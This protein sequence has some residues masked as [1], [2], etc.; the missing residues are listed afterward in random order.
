MVKQC[1][2]PC[3]TCGKDV[4]YSDHIYEKKMAQLGYS[5]P[6]YCDDCRKKHRRIK[7]SL[8][9]PYFHRRPRMVDGNGGN[10]ESCTS[11][12]H[13][14][15][16]RAKEEM[17]VQFT[18]DDYG[19]TEEQVREVFKWFENPK[20]Q[21]AILIAE[22]GA[23]KSTAMPMSMIM[24][25]NGE[26]AD[27][28]TEHGA[29]AITQPRIV[30]TDTAD[31]VG[32]QTGSCVGKGQMIGKINSRSRDTADFNNIA[33]FA[34]EGIVVNFLK[35]GKL[36]QISTLI[37]DEAHER[38]LNIDVIL[39]LVKR[40]LTQFPHLKVIIT[41]ATIDGESFRDY[42]GEDTA[43][44]IHLSG[45]ERKAEIFQNFASESDVLS[46]DNASRL[47]RGIVDHVVK[48]TKELFR[49]MKDG[50]VKTG[51]MLVFLHGIKAI[52]EA[53]EK[54]MHFFAEDD[55]FASKAIALP[56]HSRLSKSEQKRASNP[57]PNKKFKVVFSTDIAQTSVTIKNLIHV[58]D[59]GLINE[60]Q[61]D[62]HNERIVP[63]LN[64]QSSAKQRWGRVGRMQ[65]GY[66][67]CLYTEEQFESFPE[68]TTPEIQR[69]NLQSVALTLKSAGINSA[70]GGDWL[71][72]PN[73]A[74][75][76][77]VDDVLLQQGFVDEDG[78]IT[79]QGHTLMQ[80]GEYMDVAPLIVASMRY[81]CAVEMA[82][83]LPVLRPGGIRDLL[84]WDY[85]WDVYRKHYITEIQTHMMHC[86]CDDDIE[87]VLHLV[88]VSKGILLDESERKEFVETY[89]VNLPAI[90]KVLEERD[91]ILS[92]MQSGMRNLDL[93]NVRDIDMSLSEVVRI[94]FAYYM[95]EHR[96]D[97]SYHWYECQM[98]DTEESQI[99][100]REEWIEEF[101]WMQELDDSAIALSQLIE[102][103]K[104]HPCK[105]FKYAKNVDQ[106]YTR[107]YVR[108][109]FISIVLDDMKPS[110]S[111]IVTDLSLMDFGMYASYESQKKGEDVPLW[112]FG[113]HT[114]H[115]TV[116]CNYRVLITSV[117]DF[118]HGD[119]QCAVVG[120]IIFDIDERICSEENV[121]ISSDC[122]LFSS[123][124][125]ILTDYFYQK[126]DGYMRHLGCE[127]DLNNHYDLA[128][129]ERKRIVS[130]T[131]T[132]IDENGQSHFSLLHNLEDFVHKKFVQWSTEGKWCTKK[133][134]VVGIR[135]NGALEILL[136]GSDVEN[137]NF[138]IAVAHESR[139]TGDADA[140]K[141]GE[142][143]SVQV[144][145]PETK[146][147]HIILEKEKGK[148]KDLIKRGLLPSEF[149]VKGNQLQFVGWMTWD[150]L[151]QVQERLDDIVSRELLMQLYRYSNQI[152]VKEV[153]NLA[154][155]KEL[156]E[157]YPD[158]TII[159]N[160]EISYVT[161]HAMKFIIDEGVNGWVHKR[162]IYGYRDD[163]T[164]HFHAG[165][166]VHIRIVEFDDEQNSFI[167]SMKV[168]GN[169]NPFDVYSEDQL[170]YG[171][172][173]VIHE[174]SLNVDL[175][176]CVR[177]VV[178]LNEIYGWVDD[179]H[180]IVSIGDRVQVRVVSNNIEV[181]QISLSMKTLENNIFDQF[182]VGNTYEGVVY[183]KEN[184]GLRV[185]LHGRVTGLVHFSK[186]HTRS[187][188]SFAV[189]EAVDVEIINIDPDSGRVD[190]SMLLPQYDPY[191]D[192]DEGDIVDG[193]VDSLA[194][195]GWFV[196][197]DNGLK[198][199]V[200]ISNSNTDGFVEDVEDV[201][202]VGDHV[203]VEIL[204]IQDDGKLELAFC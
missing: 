66:A 69:S 44:I 37:I 50:S 17:A 47:A 188:D 99:I 8:G 129:Y 4:A 102:K 132:H 193:V 42:F 118:L 36:G 172:V 29:I 182:S 55:F 87:L 28:F 179:V 25:P 120:L 162:N 21:V 115:C 24:P 164:K 20:H 165:D 147:S 108:M 91:K 191:D 150:T 65:D 5:E 141:I 51:D 196:Q 70:S 156:R 92:K 124:L 68:H 190:L 11:V 104:N 79:T 153:V 9:M 15:R 34:T 184:Y 159:H 59:T 1:T 56:L 167:L 161:P 125:K 181:G 72:Q 12:F 122:M 75:V 185:R 39:R 138:L 202:T 114:T 45:E 137:F 158:E 166:T 98:H 89:G 35:N 54:M 183:K 157:K 201:A 175:D 189:G 171:T 119:R 169:D 110:W 81:G 85:K 163:L 106:Q 52:N 204:E 41:S 38:S 197:L 160:I 142:R 135:D 48:K 174:K 127:K 64:S 10:D 32:E 63:V 60:S 109:N 23:G 173:S 152:K 33:F 149:S 199:L 140:Y 80:F 71:A 19:V 194:S 13:P 126:H 200:H 136:D 43:A 111:R 121:L 27:L 145:S 6:E 176:S 146:I 61:W 170:Y 97:N 103:T 86:W 84:Q 77:R 131:V 130:V 16:I 187:V 49:G 67:H 95:P 112:S 3:K 148:V 96:K 107:S 58:I 117:C 144:Y 155:I 88:R 100:C 139:L 133:G 123:S 177:G 18:L 203:E 57:T 76:N 198:G 31:Y 93:T 22:T 154:R 73:E 82:T 30:A 151:V 116:N 14:E 178:P 94:L 180:K 105:F 46:Y 192:I 128:E 53:V 78:D 168:E 186:T 195:Y 40:R 83:V 2:I 134:E 90:K 7:N 74:E 143:C 101:E 26:S 113:N 62:G